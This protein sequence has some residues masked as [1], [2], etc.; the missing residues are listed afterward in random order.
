MR[1][2]RGFVLSLLVF[3]ASG[4]RELGAQ[5]TEQEARCVFAL[6]ELPEVRGAEWVQSLHDLRGCGDTIVAVIVDLWERPPRG[7]QE[8]HVLAFVSSKT[9]STRVFEAA[10]RT[11][12]DTVIRTLAELN[13]NDDDPG[14]R[15]A[16][17]HLLLQ[18]EG[19]QWFGRR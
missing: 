6:R 3:A 7:R 9:G 11:A 18:L 8:L 10:Q 19:A 15:F 1:N 13:A 17:G 14:M 4:A 5:T 12:S 2:V 16:A